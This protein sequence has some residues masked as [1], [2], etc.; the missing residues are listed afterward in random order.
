MVIIYIIL[1]RYGKKL[2]FEIL[3]TICFEN[4]RHGFVAS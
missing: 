3:Q 4:R 1:G 2:N